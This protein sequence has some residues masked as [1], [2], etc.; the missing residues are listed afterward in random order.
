MAC[1]CLR[2]SFVSAGRWFVVSVCLATLASSRA[3][4]SV[5]HFVVLAFLAFA[6]L[7]GMVP[8]LALMRAGL[9]SEEKGLFVSATFT[10][11][12]LT[13]GWLFFEAGV[14]RLQLASERYAAR[15]RIA[16][17]VHLGTLLALT[18]WAVRLTGDKSDVASFS[19][20]LLSSYAFV[21]GHFLM[22]DN[23]GRPAHLSVGWRQWNVL[24]AGSFRGFLV[25]T[26]SFVGMAV[27]AY[28][29]WP[30]DDA[31]PQRQGWRLVAPCLGLF[32]LAVPVVISRL[33]S[34]EPSPR[35]L[36]FRVSS[37]ILQVVLWSLSLLFATGSSLQPLSEVLVL[38]P[39]MVLVPA[40]GWGFFNLSEPL[41][42][43]DALSASVT[44]VA[45]TAA[46]LS[47]LTA[48]FILQR[49]DAA[50]LR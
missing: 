43:T 49:K 13:G 5:L 47:A 35:R 18:V 50:T 33:P 19:I 41:L 14:S 22:E 30:E 34:L 15:P 4:R 45:S 38:G 39:L 8:L 29:L 32:Y 23:D 1:R 20:T 17:L 16:Y 10:L 12:V 37:I 40:M 9:M 36:L 7:M 6:A 25:V 11:S 31:H 3:T 28:H 42:A 44:V 2:F 26:L 27:V 24:E 21:L 46:V 48:L